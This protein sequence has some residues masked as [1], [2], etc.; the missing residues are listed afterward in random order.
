[1]S[2]ISIDIP[3][4]SFA[5]CILE[6]IFTSTVYDPVRPEEISMSRGCSA[7]VHLDLREAKKMADKFDRLIP[8]LNTGYSQQFR[9]NRGELVRQIRT[10]EGAKT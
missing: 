2:A 5:I 8:K 9:K 3:A 6:G 7:T 4:K 10:I 1:M